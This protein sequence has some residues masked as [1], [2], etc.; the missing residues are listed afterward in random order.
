MFIIVKIFYNLKRKKYIKII[1]KILLLYFLFYFLFLFIFIYF[2]DLICHFMAH[3]GSCMDTSLGFCKKQIKRNRK[4]NGMHGSVLIPLLYLLSNTYLLIQFEFNCISLISYFTG[5][6][7]FKMLFSHQ[8]L[9]LATINER[10]T[11]KYHFLIVAIMNIA[12]TKRRLSISQDS[13]TVCLFLRFLSF[14][15]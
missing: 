3:G 4:M 2:F 9:Y 7:K 12:F 14:V 10:L 1:K 6:F 13:Y 11:K 5:V 8:L 15:N